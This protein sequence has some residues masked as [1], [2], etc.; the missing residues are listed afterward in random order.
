[1][2]GF[3]ANIDFETYPHV[4]PVIVLAEPVDRFS[5][6][7]SG[8]TAPA[9]GMKEIAGLQELEEGAEEGVVEEPYM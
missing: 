5:D 3:P 6:V 8:E 2:K 1:M 7:P 9:V 4:L